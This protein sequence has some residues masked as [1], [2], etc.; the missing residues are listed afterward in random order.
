V[1]GASLGI[2]L[3]NAL[4]TSLGVELSTGASDSVPDEVV[5]PDGEQA[6]RAAATANNR[7]ERFS[8]KWH[9]LESGGSM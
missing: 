8:N 3:G 7:I 5:L 2:S 9:L 4:G 1:L 6:R